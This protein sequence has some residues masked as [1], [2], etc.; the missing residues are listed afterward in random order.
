[1]NFS[2]GAFIASP[3]F[4]RIFGYDPDIDKPSREMLRERVHPEDLPVILEMVDKARSEKTD[5]ECE[6]RIVLSDGSI[7]HAHSVAHPVFDASGDL[8]EY[9]GTTLDVTERKRDAEVLQ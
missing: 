1:T 8:I 7:R 5:Y 6:Y 2:S 4:L 9:I 3:E